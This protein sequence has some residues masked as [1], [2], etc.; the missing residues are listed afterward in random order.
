MLR[1]ASDLRIAIPITNR[2]RRVIARIGVF[3][4]NLKATGLDYRWPQFETA[5]FVI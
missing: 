5:G 4:A 2:N 3:S 1:I